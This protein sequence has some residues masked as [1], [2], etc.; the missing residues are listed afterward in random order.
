MP[1]FSWLIIYSYCFIFI[2]IIIIIIQID[3]LWKLWSVLI[4]PVLNRF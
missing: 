4:F 3:L 1:F 2:I